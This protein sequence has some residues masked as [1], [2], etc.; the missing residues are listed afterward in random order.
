MAEFNRV[1]QD[2]RV[3]Y[4]M[5]LCPKRLLPSILEKEEPNAGDSVILHVYDALGET[6]GRRT[7][8]WALNKPDILDRTRVTNMAGITKMQS[9]CR[10]ESGPENNLLTESVKR[11]RR[12]FSRQDENYIRPHGLAGSRR[13]HHD[14]SRPV[15]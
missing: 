5:Y 10:V 2:R 15:V 13:R 9:R 8:A 14:P 6:H 7:F 12:Y 3:T 4:F 11:E 1:E